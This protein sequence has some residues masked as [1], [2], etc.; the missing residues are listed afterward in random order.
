MASPITDNSQNWSTAV[1]Q[2]DSENRHWS[3]V[4]QRLCAQSHIPVYW[5]H[6]IL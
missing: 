2:N 6:S 1:P 5:L 3:S 4:T